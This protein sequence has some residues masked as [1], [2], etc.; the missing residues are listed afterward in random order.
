[1][2]NIS[3]RTRKG[4]DLPNNPADLKLQAT[5]S[6]VPPVQLEL[7]PEAPVA[8]E[9]PTEQPQSAD[10]CVI[11]VSSCK[12]KERKGKS[13]ADKPPVYRGCFG[14]GLDGKSYW[15]PIEMNDKEL[16]KG[17]VVTVTGKVRSPFGERGDIYPIDTISCTTYE[18]PEEGAKVS[19]PSSDEL[20]KTISGLTKEYGNYAVLQAI[21]ET[22]K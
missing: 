11:R 13:A 5:E 9:A 21:A 22:M 12:L 6:P 3:K 16:A 8:I 10:G 7:V 18:E 2:P 4:G 14:K 1:M 20:F 19:A 17:D 15:W